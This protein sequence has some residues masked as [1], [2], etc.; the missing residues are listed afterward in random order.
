MNNDEIFDGLKNSLATKN[1]VNELKSQ[2]VELRKIIQEQVEESNLPDGYLSINSIVKKYELSRST[3]Y[4]HIKN[5]TLP[6]KRTFND[7][8]RVKESDLFITYMLK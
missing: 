1:E 8:I 7:K 2:I 4:R 5:K 6:A 3:V